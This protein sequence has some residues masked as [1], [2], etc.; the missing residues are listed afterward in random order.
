MHLL[1]TLSMT[2]CARR[3][4]GWKAGTWLL[5]LKRVL[6]TTLANYKNPVLKLARFALSR[7]WAFPPTQQQLCP[8]RVQTNF[9]R[10]SCF[11]LS[12]A[13]ALLA[14]SERNSDNA[15]DMES[16]DITNGVF[17]STWSG[18]ATIL[19]CGEPCT[20]P[21]SAGNALTSETFALSGATTWRMRSSCY[22]GACVRIGRLSI[23][24]ASSNACCH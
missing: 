12:A 23:T 16:C 2:S 15:S 1:P 21:P 14:S 11:S 13:R 8:C 7:R 22:S 17:S 19:K 9:G 24:M 3:R 20:R 6:P 18:V 4:S 10:E 5:R